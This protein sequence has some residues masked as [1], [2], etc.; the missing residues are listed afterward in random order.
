MQQLFFIITIIFFGSYSAMAQKTIQK[1]FSSEGIYTLTIEDD[2]IFK[3][4][5]NSSEAMPADRQEKSIKMSLHISGEHAESIIVEEKITDGT[6]SLK[7]GFA[8]F[9]TL[10]NDKLAAHKVMALEMQITLPET[11]AVEIRS[12]LASVNTNGTFKN[13]N[14]S[15][16][17]GACILTDFS[18]N[19]Q[20]K[21]IVENITVH[22]KKD[23]MGKAISKN[24]TVE[25]KLPKRGNFLVKAESING[26]ISLFQTK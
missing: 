13:L 5:I 11:M 23:V 19:A 14:I 15:L 3:I 2:A 20:L 12:K 24:G 10:E 9:F 7:T 16:G 4:E 22:A 18:G 1:K 17:N 21:T 26:S 8:P 25:N 6:L